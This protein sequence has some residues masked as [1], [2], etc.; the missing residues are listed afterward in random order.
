MAS[1]YTSDAGIIPS[2][3]NGASSKVKVAIHNQF[4]GVELVSPM[5]ASNG[6]TCY[7]LPDQRV[8]AGSTMQV[9]FSIH[10]ARLESIGIFM[11]KLQ[12]K[13]TDQSNDNI[14]SSEDEVRCTQLTFIWKVYKSGKFRVYPCPI[15]HDKDRVWNK[16]S[17]MKLAENHRTFDIKHSPVEHTWLMNDNAVLK[18]SLN[19]TREEECYK[20]EMTISKGTMNDNT[21]KP[22]YIG[23]DR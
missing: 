22:Q 8:D 3:W 13:N 16:D 5:Y 14:I 6:A 15:E 7:L 21:C 9:G 11:Y 2:L 17:M 10:P 23:L 12:K 18:T 4:P 1:I 20:L 19:V